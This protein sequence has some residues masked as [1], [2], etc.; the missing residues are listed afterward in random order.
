MITGHRRAAV[1]ESRH[2]PRTQA[3]IARFMKYITPSANR[4]RNR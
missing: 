3:A 4:P 1:D 2:C